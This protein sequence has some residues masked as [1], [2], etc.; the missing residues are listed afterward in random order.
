MG[1]FEFDAAL[2][3]PP[4]IVVQDVV[5]DEATES[6]GFTVRSTSLPAPGE[7]VVTTLDVESL[8]ARP[9]IDFANFDAVDVTLNENSSTR[10]G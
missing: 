4:R 1:A 8:T 7:T 2:H 10:T 6:L 5:A 3:Q 9:Q